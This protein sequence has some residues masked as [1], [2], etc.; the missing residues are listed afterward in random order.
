MWVRV[1]SSG[2]QETIIR[3]RISRHPLQVDAIII[4]HKINV[5]KNFFTELVLY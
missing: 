5:T 2:L 1:V 3:I 4:N